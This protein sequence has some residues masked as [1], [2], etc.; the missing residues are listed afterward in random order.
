MH[1]RI[2]I[3]TND[4]ASYCDVEISYT[5][6]S[7]ISQYIVTTMINSHCNKETVAHTSSDDW[8]IVM[9]MM[10]AAVD[11]FNYDHYSLIT[12]SHRNEMKTITCDK[13]ALT[14]H[15]YRTLSGIDASENLKDVGRCILI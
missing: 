13:A 5:N 11:K 7:T 12:E 8:K 14:V 3:K 10:I 6:E 15:L 2:A 9:R 4:E 1:T